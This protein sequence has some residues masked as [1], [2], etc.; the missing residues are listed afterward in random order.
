MNKCIVCE[1]AKIIYYEPPKERPPKTCPNCGRDTR[2][3]ASMKEDDPRVGILVE[4]YRSRLGYADTD[5]SDAK[6]SQVKD[7]GGDREADGGVAESLTDEGGRGMADVEAVTGGLVEEA[8]RG[9]VGIVAVAGGLTDEADVGMSGSEVVTAG[10]TDEADSGK[11]HSEAV[12]GSRIYSLVSRDGKI[13][14]E[15]PVDGGVIGRTAIGGEA[16][17]HNGRISREHVRLTPAKRAQGVMAEDL[18]AN[19]TYV[20][21]RRLVRGKE[22]FVVIGSVLSMGGE[23]FVLSK[24]NI[25]SQSPNLLTIYKEG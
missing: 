16:L 17:A 18:S 4:K 12:T 20:D 11:P 7:E 24:D 5:E 6:E 22:E 21:G 9:T 8:D 10:L 19:G 25:V 3:Y 15:L 13:R 23:D 2:H 14:I 1:C